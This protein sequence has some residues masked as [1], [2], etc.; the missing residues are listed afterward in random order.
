VKVLVGPLL[1]SRLQCVW[2]FGCFDSAPRHHG[3]AHYESRVQSEA[4]RLTHER[5][6]VALN[7]NLK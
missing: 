5:D 7:I 6:A 2:A 4:V 3:Q 1:A